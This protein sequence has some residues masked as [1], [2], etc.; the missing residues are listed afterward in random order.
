MRELFYQLG[1]YKVYRELKPEIKPDL[2]YE[3]KSALKLLDK[4][5]YNYDNSDY[6]KLRNKIINQASKFYI[7]IVS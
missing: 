7:N 4:N 3:L 6:N 2:L 5:K 1:Y